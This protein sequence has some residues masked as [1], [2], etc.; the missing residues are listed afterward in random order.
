PDEPITRE[1]VAAMVT[2]ALRVAGKKVTL[3]PAER[4]QLLAVFAD[5]GAIGNWALDAVAVAVKEDIV[6][7]RTADSFAPQ[8]G[9]TRA[10]AVTMLK[11]LLTSV[12]WLS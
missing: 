11:R 1:Q 4:D 9:A 6:R 8:M 12:G 2:R 10:E 7:G 5:R 3:T